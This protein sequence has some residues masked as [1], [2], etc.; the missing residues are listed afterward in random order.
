ML[1]AYWLVAGQQ[2]GLAVLSG[3]STAVHGA[4]DVDVLGSSSRALALDVKLLG[5]TS[6]IFLVTSVPLI[7]V[8]YSHVRPQEKNSVRCCR[9][10]SRNDSEFIARNSAFYRP[11]KL[12]IGQLHTT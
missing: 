4:R 2:N 5:A 7:N 6:F 10:E 1:S 12:S 11:N 8:P 3:P 9:F